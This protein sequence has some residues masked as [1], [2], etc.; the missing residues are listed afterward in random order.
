MAFVL[1]TFNP[2]VD[3]N[4]GYQREHK[5]KILKVEFGDGY[6]QR[7]ADGINNDARKF[8]LTWTH[9]HDHEK[10]TIENFFEA[11]NGLESFFY[12]FPDESAPRAYVCETW[13]VQLVNYNV[14][15][16]TAE[17]MEVFDL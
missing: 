12:Q 6:A 16:I 11:R 10:E 7:A 3:P 8:S 13:G 1:H 14:Y 2:P 15:T 5:P 9:L 4:P 17:F